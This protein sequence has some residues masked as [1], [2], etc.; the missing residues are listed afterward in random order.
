[1]LETLLPWLVKIGGGALGA[2]VIGAVLKKF[3]LGGLLGTIVGGL[4]G[5]FGPK[6]LEM[7][8]LLAKTMTEGGAMDLGQ[9]AQQG[10]L[11]AA[12]GGA[13]AAILGLLK[14]LLVKSKNPS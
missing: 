6:L 4:G 14:G 1:M 9:A 11:G 12:S 2:N 13:L 8:G 5:A 7:F 3:S 10:S